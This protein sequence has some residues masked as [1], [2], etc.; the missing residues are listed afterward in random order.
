MRRLGRLGLLAGAALALL[1]TPVQAHPFLASGHTCGFQSGN[2]PPLTPPG[3]QLASITGGPVTATDGP[4]DPTGNPVTVTIRCWIQV[5]GTGTYDDT[6]SVVP[7]S[8]VTATGTGSA[9]IPPTTFTYRDSAPSI[10]VCTEWDL[11]DLTDT[12]ATPYYF[13]S[14]SGEFVANGAW[15]SCDLATAQEVSSTD[16]EYADTAWT[17]VIK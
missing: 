8:V 11:R 3:T 7:G 13:D 17:A 14:P 9:T 2:R 15:A 6:A 5:G 1:A 16:T 10:Y 4:S 12:T